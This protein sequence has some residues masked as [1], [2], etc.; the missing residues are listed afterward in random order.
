MQ[1]EQGENFVISISPKQNVACH[2]LKFYFSTHF[3]TA[4]IYDFHRMSLPLQKVILLAEAWTWHYNEKNLTHKMFFIFSWQADKLRGTKLFLWI[5]SCN[6]K[7]QLKF[8]IFNIF[9]SQHDHS[10]FYLKA[11]CDNFLRLFS[12]DIFSEA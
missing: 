9:K 3:E 8:F 4:S 1:H 7:T 12:Y 2:L 11:P 5:I 10:K 6:L